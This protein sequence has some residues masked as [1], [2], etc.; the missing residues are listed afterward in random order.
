MKQIHAQWLIS[1]YNKLGNSGKM[2]KSAS[3]NVSI[4]EVIG[5]KEISDDD[6]LNP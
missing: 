4:M 6:R 1:L 5:N 3:Q 2:I